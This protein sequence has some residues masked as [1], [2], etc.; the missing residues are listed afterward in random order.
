MVELARPLDFLPHAVQV[1]HIPIWRME[2]NLAI[3]IVAL[4]AVA[5]AVPI[6]LIDP[7]LKRIM[8]LDPIDAAGPD[9]VLYLIKDL[10]GVRHKVNRVGVPDHIKCVFT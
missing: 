7:N 3:L 10:S 2:L 4:D 9:D 8:P 5:G 6:G 1:W